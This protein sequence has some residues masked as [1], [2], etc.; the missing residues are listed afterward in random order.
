M[1]IEMEHA[2]SSSSAFSAD[3]I[4]QQAAEAIQASKD[5]IAERPV[6]SVLAS[7]GVGVAV[8]L[9]LAQ[10]L[11]QGEK[12]RR[13]GFVAELGKQLTSNLGQWV[14]QNFPYRS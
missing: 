10:V 7:V 8:G 14:P 13:E 3:A 2:N 9:V 11:S 5:C 6:S 4:Q 12:Q 1:A